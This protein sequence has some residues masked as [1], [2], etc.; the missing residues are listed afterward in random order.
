MA[1][2]VLAMAVSCNKNDA[3]KKSID[4]IVL[5]DGKISYSVNIEAPH[6][7]QTAVEYVSEINEFVN[8]GL[9]ETAEAVVC[10]ALWSTDILESK[11]TIEKT[12]TDKFMFGTNGNKEIKADETYY[13]AVVALDENGEFE[14]K[15]AIIIT[16]PETK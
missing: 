1:A 16:Y 7:Y 5:T 3:A 10:Q 11:G 14:N 8:M 15:D 2:A 12:K 6:G 9:Y 4:D 13:I